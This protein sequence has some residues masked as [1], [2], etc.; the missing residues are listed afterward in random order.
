MTEAAGK[1][2]KTKYDMSKK[3]L[4]KKKKQE[5]KDVAME[6]LKDP[7]EFKKEV[8]S[9]GF[10]N[11]EVPVGKPKP[12]GPP[13]GFLERQKKAAA[14]EPK[15]EEKVPESVPKADNNDAPRE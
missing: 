14:K 7:D 15:E 5:K 3:E 8:E 10:K 11:D 9:M 6:E 4:A 1:Y 12:K 2:V 13:A